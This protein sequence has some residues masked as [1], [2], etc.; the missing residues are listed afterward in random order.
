MAVEAAEVADGS[1]ADNLP[2]LFSSAGAVRRRTRFLDAS[3]AEGTAAAAVF[4]AKAAAVEEFPS[5]F[6]PAKAK[7]AGPD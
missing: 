7:L 2:D 3:R 5:P 6:W 1:G 4:L